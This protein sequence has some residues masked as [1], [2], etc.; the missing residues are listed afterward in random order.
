MKFYM[1]I[2]SVLPL[3][4]LCTLLTACE[5]EKKQQQV[6][7]PQAQLE[8]LDKAPVALNFPGT[9]FY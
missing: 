6:I 5:A 7:I 8:A 1:K 4:V 9:L 2:P 3:A